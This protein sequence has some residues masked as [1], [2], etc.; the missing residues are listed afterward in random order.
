MTEWRIKR[1]AELKREGE[2][3]INPMSSESLLDSSNGEKGHNLFSC[4]PHSFSLKNED[5]G[6]L[7]RLSSNSAL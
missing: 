4:T 6:G 2:R 7:M 5:S 3:Q 1:R